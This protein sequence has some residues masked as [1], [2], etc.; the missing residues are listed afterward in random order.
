MRDL[1]T[2]VAKD[3]RLQAKTGELLAS[4]FI[5]S[6]LVVL[7]LSLAS[8]PVHGN[9]REGIHVI[10]STLWVALAFAGV[11][12][13]TRVIE[14]ERRDDCLKSLRLA[15]VSPSIL[16]LAKTTTNAILLAGIQFLTVPVTFVF[17]DATTFAIVPRLAFVLFLGIA[18]FSAVG[19]VMAAISTRAGGRESLLSILILPLLVPV[20]LGGIEATKTLLAEGAFLNPNSIFWLKLLVVYDIVFLAVASLVFEY[21][22]EE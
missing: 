2:L 5:Y 6:L 4:I 1:L 22:I 3:L 8:A 10:A 13:A 7:I 20:L 16:Y 9:M 19:T 18:G 15:G 12:G 17:D 11:V 14:I 21:L